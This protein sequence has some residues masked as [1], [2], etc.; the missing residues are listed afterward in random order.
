M[1]PMGKG[2]SVRLFCCWSVGLRTITPNLHFP[3]L[4]SVSYTAEGH[5]PLGLQCWGLSGPLIFSWNLMDRSG[6][7]CCTVTTLRTR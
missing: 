4:Q 3:I 6:I 7:S 2:Q 1:E 5:G